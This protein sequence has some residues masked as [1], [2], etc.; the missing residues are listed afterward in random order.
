M[1]ITQS[2]QLINSNFKGHYIKVTCSKSTTKILK[3]GVKYVQG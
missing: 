3:K 1:Q 2:S